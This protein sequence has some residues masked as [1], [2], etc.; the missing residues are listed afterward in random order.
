[1]WVGLQLSTV[2][3]AWS[4]GFRGRES[5]CTG[6]TAGM[7]NILPQVKR[8]L[9]SRQGDDR[10]SCWRP[11][12]ADPATRPTSYILRSELSKET[13]ASRKIFSVNRPPTR[14]PNGR[15]LERTL[16]Q[17][18]QFTFPLKPSECGVADRPEIVFVP[19]P[20]LTNQEI[21][22]EPVESLVLKIVNSLYDAVDLFVQKKQ[23]MSTAVVKRDAEIV[24]YV[25]CSMF[26][27]LSSMFYVPHFD[28]RSHF[29][30]RI[31]THMCA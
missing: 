7:I 25:L 14:E 24:R 9:S 11:A 16:A 3:L 6:C 12:D 31:H 1:M 13:A 21:L 10:L 5:S 30:S 17:A 2:W 4:V 27:C 23:Q 20:S 8:S 29:H 26:S 22:V 28:N 19:P 15:Y 18:L